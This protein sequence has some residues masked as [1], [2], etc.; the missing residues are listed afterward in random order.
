LH[1]LNRRLRRENTLYTL[2]DGRLN[3]KLSDW[4]AVRY[5]G[6]IPPRSA[7]RYCAVSG[8]SWTL[9]VLTARNAGDAK[10]AKLL[11]F[12]TSLTLDQR[13]WLT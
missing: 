5:Q 9:L 3:N 7:R 8:T 11:F 1:A 13:P 12:P 2:H 6:A 4:F 10:L